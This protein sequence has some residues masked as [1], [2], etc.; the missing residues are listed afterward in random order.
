MI[1]LLIVSSI[2]TLACPIE[3][4]TTVISIKGHALSVELAATPTSRGCGLSHRKD[5]TQNHGMLF[6]FPD[7]RPRSFWMKDTFIPLSIAFLDK[8]GKILNILDMVPMQTDPQYQSG[9]PASYALE[10]NQ[11]WFHA[12]GIEIG[13]IVEMKLPLVLN[14]R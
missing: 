8:S 1:F 13:D 6:I 3:L 10:V 7:S 4:P 9:R 14:I 12:H 2:N 5:L 11:G